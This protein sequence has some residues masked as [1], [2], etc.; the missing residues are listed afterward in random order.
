MYRPS[1]LP[2]LSEPNGSGDVSQFKQY[3]DDYLRLELERIAEN[4]TTQDFVQLVKL[5][6][7]PEKPRDGLTVYAD[8]TNWN[9]GSGEGVYT[10]Y[11]A[12]WRKLG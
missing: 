4:F 12:A 3:L 10:Y 8:G 5:N 1:P 9:P 7:E 6:V 11:A 2:A